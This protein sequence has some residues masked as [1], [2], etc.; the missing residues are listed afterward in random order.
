MKTIASVALV[1]SLLTGPRGSGQRRL[2]SRSLERFSQCP[3]LEVF[4]TSAPG[5]PCSYLSKQGE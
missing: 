3:G 5:R 1:L 4:L 2:R